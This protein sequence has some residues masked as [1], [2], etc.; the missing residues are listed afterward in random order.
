[1]SVLPRLTYGFNLIQSKCQQGVYVC[2]RERKRERQG[3]RGRE[4]W[5]YLKSDLKFM[6]KSKGTKIAHCS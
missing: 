5:K 1:M 2:E 4:T 6:K 3:K